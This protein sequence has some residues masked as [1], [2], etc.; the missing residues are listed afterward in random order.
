[1]LVLKI[2]ELL[3]AFFGGFSCPIIMPKCTSR[4]VFLYGGLKF[5]SAKA[6]SFPG[7]GETDSEN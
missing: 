2:L 6:T 3:L 4:H 5:A 7:F 1:M